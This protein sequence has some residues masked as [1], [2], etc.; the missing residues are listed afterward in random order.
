MPSTPRDVRAAG[1]AAALL[2]AC[3][4]AALGVGARPAAAQKLPARLRD[5]VYHHAPIVLAETWNEEVNPEATD[6]I[7]PVDFDCD[8]LGGNNA[9]RAYVPSSFCDGRAT[10]YFSIVETG[11]SSAS[12]Y[13][14][15]GYYFYHANQPRGSFST[16][17]GTYTTEVHQHDFEGVWLVV[18][19]S[20]YS[21]YGTLVG[22]LTQAHGA[23]IP[24]GRRTGDGAALVYPA[25]AGAAGYIYFWTDRS[26]GVRR[27]VVAI[28]SRIH[29]TFMAQDYTDR[30]T[31][32]LHFGFGIDPRSPELRGA[33]YATVHRG[34]QPIVYEP[35]PPGATAR[36]L[37]ASVR[38]GV[39]K[40]RLVEVTESPLWTQRSAP[41]VLFTGST[42]GLGGGRVGLSAF[43]PSAG[44][45]AKAKPMWNWL[46][47]RGERRVILGDVAHWYTFGVDMTSRYYSSVWWPTT[48]PGRLLTAP[49]AEAGRRFLGLPDLDAPPRYNPYVLTITLTLVP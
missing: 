25:A 47:G 12:G 40:Y 23:L 38:R 27:P 2:V 31:W 16:P 22:A 37:G 13:Y 49:A 3:A 48:S 17:I 15:I 28:R 33:Y 24:F 35:V 46:G 6:H 18:Q 41:G 32:G 36:R 29:G 30:T 1:R 10:A 7:L 5:V 26:S 21:P 20:P 42:L 45:A 9:A 4:L 43:A 8:Q 39:W 19:K 14:F 11:S 34:T 44:A